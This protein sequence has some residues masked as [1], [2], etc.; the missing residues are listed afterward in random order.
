I[1]VLRQAQQATDQVWQ[2]LVAHNP[3]PE[4]S[5]TVAKLKAHLASEQFIDSWDDIAASTK[6]VLDA[7]RSAYCDLFDRRK[8]SYESA[9]GEIKN[10]TEWG[11]LEANNPSMATSLLSPLLGR[12]GSEAVK[13]GTLLGKSSLTEMESDLAAVDGL[14]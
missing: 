7:Y 2:R 1:G 6:T 11:P 13:G 12:V 4:L 8:K 3:S 10:R 9:I 5:A 14:K